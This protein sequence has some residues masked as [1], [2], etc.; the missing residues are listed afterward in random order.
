MSDWRWNNKHR[1]WTTQSN[2]PT[3]TW[4]LKRDAWVYENPGMMSAIEECL[5]NMT[6]F[7][8]AERILNKLTQPRKDDKDV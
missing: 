2:Y 6:R 5:D 3:Y 1:V 8:D 7:P 4:S